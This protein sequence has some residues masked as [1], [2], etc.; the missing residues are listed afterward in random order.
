MSLSL[1][2][3]LSHSEGYLGSSP[4]PGCEFPA[5]TSPQNTGEKSK[6]ILFNE[7]DESEWSSLMPKH[8]IFLLNNNMNF[9]YSSNF[10]PVF[11]PS[12]HLLKS[13]FVAS[14]FHLDS[15]VL[16]KR[17]HFDMLFVIWKLSRSREL[18]KPTLLDPDHF[19]GSPKNKH[20][21]PL[22]WRTLKR[23][24]FL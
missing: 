6:I 10:D 20:L 9:L 22:G 11:S 21:S 2:W 16:R 15:T 5:C 12:N 13:T 17:D 3:R 8:D 18:T 24:L 4:D 1:S 14:F 19:P 23:P 7:Y